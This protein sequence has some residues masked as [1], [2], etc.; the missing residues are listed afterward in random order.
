MQR[1]YRWSWLGAIALA[2]PTLAAAQDSSNPSHTVRE[3]DTLW[4]LART[5]RGD[6]FLWPDIFR[7]NTSVVEDPHWI[8]PGEILRLSAGEGV[9]VGPGAGYAGAGRGRFGD[10]PA[11]PSADPAGW[12]R[13]PRPRWSRWVMRLA[14]SP[15]AGH[16]SRRAGAGEPGLAHH[17]EPGR[18]PVCDRPLRPPQ[19]RHHRGDAEGVHQHALPGAAPQRVLLVRLPDREA[20]ASLRQGAR[21][22]RPAPDPGH[23]AEHQRHA[24]LLD[25][26]VRA[27]GRPLPGRRHPAG[28][29]ARPRG[30]GLW[31]RGAAQRNGPGHRHRERQVPRE[32]DRGIRSDPWG[33]ER[34]AAREV[35]P[36]RGPRRPRRSAAECGRVCWA[37]RVART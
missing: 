7:M 13:L 8:Y 1:T 11:A 30:R 22:G 35:H 4:E 25:R 21:T 20:E 23:G 12:P 29:A 15:V 2:V 27:E 24:L 26:G 19:R 16:R 18:E 14:E 34:A 33:P 37:G 28:R 10:A 17:A 6:P 9:A 3:G 36:S 5:Y 31:R 32:R